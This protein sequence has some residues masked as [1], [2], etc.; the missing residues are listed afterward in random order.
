M[1]KLKAMKMP[2][3]P[4]NPLWNLTEK[5]LVFLD[6]NFFGFMESW[7][8]Y[9][10]IVE[11]EVTDYK[12][13]QSCSALFADIDAGDYLQQRSTQIERLFW[14]NEHEEE[15]ALPENVDKVVLIEAWKKLV[16][17]NFGEG[18]EYTLF[19]K[20]ALVSLESNIQV[21]PPRRYLAETCGECRYK[22]FC[23]ENLEDECPDCRYREF[24]LEKGCEEY[25]Y[26]NQLKKDEIYGEDN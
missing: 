7:R 21:D 24:A 4:R 6:L 25:D 10:Y 9:K 15:L 18:E 5:E 22:K 23:E 16:A 1:G 3:R 13:K 14:P 20:K 11:P 8:L 17:G 26:K 12:A 2:E 19:L